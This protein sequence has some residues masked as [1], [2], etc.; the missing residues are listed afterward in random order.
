MANISNKALQE[1]ADEHDADFAAKVKNLKIWRRLHTI[2]RMFDLETVDDEGV[3][4][5]TARDDLPRN[6]F[7]VVHEIIGGV[8]TGKIISKEDIEISIFTTGILYK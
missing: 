7:F 3:S 4:H 1:W 2:A 8:I 6:S 5:G